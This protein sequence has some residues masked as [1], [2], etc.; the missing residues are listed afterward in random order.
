ME[1][2]SKLSLTRQAE[3]FNSVVNSAANGLW[4]CHANDTSQFT[5]VKYG[6]LLLNSYPTIGEI[7]QFIAVTYTE[8]DA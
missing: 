1:K 3:Q 8:E 2:F 7:Q 6:F 4:T 5:E